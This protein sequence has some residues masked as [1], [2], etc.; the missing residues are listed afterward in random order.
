MKIAIVAAAF[1]G[2]LA[3]PAFADRPG[4]GWVSQ[5]ALTRMVAKQG[6]R[7]TKVEADEGH[8]EGEMIRAGKI[9]EF[10]ADPRTGRLTKAELKHHDHD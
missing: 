2:L 1:T 3:A 6:Y 5:A 9:Y 8:W 4:P 10:H 7:I